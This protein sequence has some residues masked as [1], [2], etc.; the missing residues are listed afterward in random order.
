MC[1][2]CVRVQLLCIEFVLKMSPANSQ[3]VVEQALLLLALT[4]ATE[5][6]QADLSQLHYEK[7]ESNCTQNALC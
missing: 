7:M 1:E 6:A 4:A 5:R 2:C 3:V